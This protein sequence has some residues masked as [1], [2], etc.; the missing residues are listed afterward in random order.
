M[1]QAPEAEEDRLQV[2]NRRDGDAYNTEDK[3]FTRWVSVKYV[4]YGR[5]TA[6]RGVNQDLPTGAAVFEGG[7]WISPTEYLQI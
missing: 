1:R 5:I 2:A 4:K 7:S 6:P 3:I